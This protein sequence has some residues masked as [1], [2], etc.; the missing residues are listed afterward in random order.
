[1]T[2]KRKGAK[3]VHMRGKSKG[4]SGHRTKGPPAPRGHKTRPRNSRPPKVTLNGITSKHIIPINSYLTTFNSKI[5]G[6]TK[7]PLIRFLVNAGCFNYAIPSADGK[8]FTEKQV[9]TSAVS[10][11]IRNFEKY[12][13]TKL[14]IKL[15]P[16]TPRVGWCGSLA[17][18]AQDSMW[19]ATPSTVESIKRYGN[20]L[21]SA[22]KVA[23]VFNCLRY[24]DRGM[25]RV[26]G[27]DSGVFKSV[28]TNS[29]SALTQGPS[30]TVMEFSQEF[31]GTIDLG[32]SG[33][34]VTAAAGMEYEVHI[35]GAL[36]L[37]RFTATPTSSKPNMQT[38]AKDT[39]F[40]GASL[41]GHDFLFRATG[42]NPATEA[43]FGP[44]HQSL[45]GNAFGTATVAHAADALVAKRAGWYRVHMDCHIMLRAERTSSDGT[46]QV[47]PQEGSQIV[48]QFALER[49]GINLFSARARTVFR[50]ENRK[51]CVKNQ[52]QEPRD[53]VNNTNRQ[54]FAY[55]YTYCGVSSHE[56]PIFISENDV[57]NVAIIRPTIKFSS[58]GGNMDGTPGGASSNYIQKSDSG[59]NNKLYR[60]TITVNSYTIRLEYMNN[61]DASYDNTGFIK[62]DSYKSLTDGRVVK[63]VEEVTD[64][65]E[66]GSFS[67]EEN[68]NVPP[69]GELQLDDALL[70][71]AEGSNNSSGEASD[72]DRQIHLEQN[73]ATPK[74]KVKTRE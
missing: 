47:A 66:V 58:F 13:F 18:S 50:I 34:P 32:M 44:K 28:S 17:M 15:I 11:T 54:P 4:R 14:E 19:E 23:T 74:L 37:S 24:L 9:F 26:I 51:Y 57:A 30:D 25:K 2:G 31:A 29:V 60:P 67:D 63:H 70:H 55:G 73:R 45:D 39:T 61:V 5:T 71:N 42:Y 52:Y 56:N 1:M 7:E 46:I 21:T 38:Y 64:F 36:E 33:V 68:G 53:S 62:I 10:N 59:A 6:A 40:S 3:G 65:D 69:L 35:I 41:P 43:T 8:S 49:A 27:M 22:P 20:T 72:E 16:T 48:C 12:R